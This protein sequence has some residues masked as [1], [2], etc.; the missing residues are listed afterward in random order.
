VTRRTESIVSWMVMAVLAAVA[1]AVLIAQ[2]DYDPSLF[3]PEAAAR[4]APTET[5]R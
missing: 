1:A 3:S 2:A 5:T 4:P